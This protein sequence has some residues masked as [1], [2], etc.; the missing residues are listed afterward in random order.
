M[1]RGEACQGGPV[2]YHGLQQ[3]GR[4]AAETTDISP[5]LTAPVS[6]A[7]AL[8]ATIRARP[9]GLEPPGGGF[10]GTERAGTRSNG[11]KQGPEQR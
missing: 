9:E 6:A 10:D 2:R 11:H 4:S 5:V 1:G 3:P 8:F 7:P